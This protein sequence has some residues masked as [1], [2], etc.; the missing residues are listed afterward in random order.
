[1]FKIFF[2]FVPFVISA[3]TFQPSVNNSKMTLVSKNNAPYEL[4]SS[5]LSQKLSQTSDALQFHID[6]TNYILEMVYVSAKG[7]TC[8]RFIEIDQTMNS[9]LY[10]QSLQGWYKVNALTAKA[11]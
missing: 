7:Q 5:S 3:C 9:L 10:C 2:S 6:G 8:K 1:M 11:K 4:V